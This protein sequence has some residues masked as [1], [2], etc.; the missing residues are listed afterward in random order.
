MNKK[1]WIKHHPWVQL[2]MALKNINIT[3]KK[4]AEIIQKSETEVNELINWKRNITTDWANRIWI[5]LWLNSKIWL[6][7]QNNYD[8]Y[9]YFQNQE[10]LNILKK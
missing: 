9:I 4:F 8:Q 1:N 3:Q 6:N 10:N 7:M 2:K 5:Y